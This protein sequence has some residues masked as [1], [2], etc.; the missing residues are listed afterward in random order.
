VDLFK[1]APDRLIQKFRKINER[2]LPPDR[3]LTSIMMGLSAIEEVYFVSKNVVDTSVSVSGSLLYENNY[4]DRRLD[5]YQGQRR[6]IVLVTGYMQSPMSF[7]RLERQLSS[8]VFDSF[9]YIWGDF[10]YSQD[11]T[12]TSSQLESVL[13]EVVSNTAAEEIYLVG[14]SQGGIIIRAMVQH[15]MGADLP[16]K[17]CL[18][19][20]SPH[21]GTWAALAAIPHRGLLRLVGLVPYIR[22]VIGESGLQLL[23]GSDF[24]HELNSRPLP[25]QIK[26]YSIF[27]A[28]DPMIWPPTSAIFPY[29]EAQNHF[30]QKFGHA[31]PLYCSRAHNIAVNCLFGDLADSRNAKETDA[32]VVDVSQ[33]R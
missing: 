6:L 30:I 22:K 3:Y 19:L 16:I 18:F 15:G 29:P 21:Q 2:L 8:E 5:E 27:Y 9:T 17:K 20:S 26:F 11:L 23:P 1:K 10:P 7:Y 14:H 4:H 33:S 28:L 25:E 32:G 31:Q 13:R 12:L 24:L